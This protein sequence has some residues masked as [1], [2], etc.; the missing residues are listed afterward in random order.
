MIK[1]SVLVLTDIIQ[2]AIIIRA[3]M[4][5]IPGAID[6]KAY[7]VI[8]ML[9]EPIEGP[10]RNLM[11]RYFEGPIDFSPIIAIFAIQFIRMIIGYIF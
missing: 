3:I 11:N 9:T 1:Y 4:S 10:I 7:D 8:G 6:S 2:Y 5:W